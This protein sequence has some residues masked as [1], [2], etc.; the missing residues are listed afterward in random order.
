MSDVKRLNVFSHIGGNLGYN[1][2]AR[3]F[4]QGLFEIGIETK[5]VPWETLRNVK[6]DNKMETAVKK[7]FM[8][9]APSVCLSYADSFYKFFGEKRIGYTVWETT[10]LPTD[11]SKHINYLDEVWTVSKFCEETFKNSGIDIPIKIVREGVDTTVYNPFVNKIEEIPK[12]VF[13][14][15][16]VF[17]WENR[18]SPEILIEAF[19]EEFDKKEDVA[20]LLNT[21]NPFIPNFNP[22]VALFQ[23]NLPIHP[24]IVPIGPFKTQ[25][26]MAKHYATAN[27]FVLPTK[28]EAWGLPMIEAMACGTPVITTNWSG[29]LEF[30]KK[31]YGWLIDVERME[32]PED[33]LFRG[34][35][36][37]SGNEWAIPSKKH[38]KE[39]MRYA[40]ENK[41][42]CTKKGYSAYEHVEENFTWGKSVSVV[43]EIL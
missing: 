27:C 42:E 23:M 31:D 10:K 6:L 17:K 30:M 3:G 28:G 35:E 26:E 19:A 43:K 12:N 21:H 15:Y 1:A 39:L 11:W 34:Y 29:A 7:S 13:L 9:D 8:Y 14:F 33:R 4:V 18:K 41:D 32:M 25:A 40:F 20:L 16:S 2:H 38:L 37:R 5:I 24:P 36:P 22:Y